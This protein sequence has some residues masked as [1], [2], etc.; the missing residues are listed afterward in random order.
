MSDICLFITVPPEANERYERAL[1][2]IRSLLVYIL[3]CLYP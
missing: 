1:V 3:I 2:Y